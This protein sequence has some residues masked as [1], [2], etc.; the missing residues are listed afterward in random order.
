ME[1]IAN[2]RLTNDKTRQ[3]FNDGDTVKDGDF[4][5]ATIKRWVERGHLEVKV[6]TRGK[7]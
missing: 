4:T 2:T 3:V 6:K 5:K 7:K 1:Y